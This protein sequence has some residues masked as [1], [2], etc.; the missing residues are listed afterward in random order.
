MYLLQRL[1]NVCQ[2]RCIECV[3]RIESQN[4]HNFPHSKSDKSRTNKKKLP[5]KLCERGQINST[6]IALLWWV[7]S[8]FDTIQNY[9]ECLWVRNVEWFV[10][11]LRGIFA[12]VI[13]LY[14]WTKT[15]ISYLI[16]RP[17]RRRLRRQPMYPR[18]ALE[19]FSLLLFAAQCTII[20]IQTFS[21]ICESRR[22]HERWTGYRGWSD[23]FSACGLKNMCA[24]SNNFHH[25]LLIILLLFS[26]WKSID[27]IS[28]N[29]NDPVNWY[30]SEKLTK[31][32]ARFHKQT[33]RFY[34]E[35]MIAGGAL[36]LTII[37]IPK[38]ITIIQRLL[39]QT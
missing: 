37:I 32:S 25:F 18:Y 11:S 33:L 21:M 38:C 36:I 14:K 29:R 34:N 22:R 13:T 9:T 23:L 2:S 15:T 27:V 17:R 31:S 30:S 7:A 16:W 4:R 26:R 19:T 1:Q 35:S 28:W 24:F 39:A 20:S 10:Q 5:K 12:C 3:R 8:A 6:F